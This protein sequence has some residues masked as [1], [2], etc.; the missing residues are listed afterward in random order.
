MVTHLK[1][2]YTGTKFKLRKNTSTST[3]Q[4]MFLKYCFLYTYQFFNMLNLKTRCK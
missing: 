1:T 3:P 2:N 4:N